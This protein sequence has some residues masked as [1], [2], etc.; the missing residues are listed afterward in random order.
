[1]AKSDF[2]PHS[3]DW[4]KSPGPKYNEI[5]V[6][7]AKVKSTHRGK[8]ETRNLFVLPKGWKGDFAVDGMAR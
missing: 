7:A 5:F 1:M 3:T 6:D 2:P 4:S 8:V